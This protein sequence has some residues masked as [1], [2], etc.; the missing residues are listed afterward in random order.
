MGRPAGRAETAEWHMT[1]AEHEAR[2]EAEARFMPVRPVKKSA[3]LKLDAPAL[4]HWKRIMKDMKGLDI[5]DALDADALGI[6]CAKLARRDDLQARYLELRAGYEREHDAVVL[7]MMLKISAELQSVEAQ[8]LAYAS[9]L[10]LTPESRLRMARRAAEPVE[11]DPN[12][13]LFG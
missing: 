10:G 6:Y 13:D 12:A 3:L 8:L 11:D 2:S 7:K 4:K 1:A 5:L 9:R